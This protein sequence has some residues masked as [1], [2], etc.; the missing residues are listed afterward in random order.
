[1]FT[2][3]REDVA[4]LLRAADML[5]LPSPAEHFGRVL[6]EAMALEVPVIACDRAGPSE[7]VVHGSSGLLVQPG[8]AEQIADA[9]ASLAADPERRRLL[10]EAGRRRVEQNYTMERHAHL[11]AQV[12]DAT[13][14]A[15]PTR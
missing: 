3:H 7:I 14:L 4:D 6:I 12:Y 13:M 2:G 9:I 1:M 8:S 11:V 5:V 15:A 10:G